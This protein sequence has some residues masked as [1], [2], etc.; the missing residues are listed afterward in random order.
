[1]PV[2]VS[3]NPALDY[4]YV[5][6]KNGDYEY[7]IYDITGNLIKNERIKKSSEKIDV[8]I[9]SSG[10]YFIKIISERKCMQA[11]FMKK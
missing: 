6:L 1:L 5:D 8:S 9:F 10:S 7:S 4:I 2:K 11:I 3:P